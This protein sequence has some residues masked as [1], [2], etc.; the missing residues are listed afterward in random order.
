MPRKETSRPPAREA[1]GVFSES[2]RLR[3]LVFTCG[4]SLMAWEIAGSRVLG[5]YFGST[6]YVWGSLIGVIMG[7]LS[8]GYY[9]GGI[10]ADR[11]PSVGLLCSIVAAAGVVLLI[12]RFIAASVCRG[13]VT[14]PLGARMQPL[15]VSVVLFL[16][17]SVLLGMVSPF[18]VRR[19]AKSVGTMGNV[20]GRLYAL[21]TV[22]SIAGTLAAA[23]Y[24]LETFRVSTII[25]MLGGLL[26]ASALFLWLPG[27]LHKSRPVSA[28]LLAAAA[29]LC[30]SVCIPASTFDVL[31]YYSGQQ[32]IIIDELESAYQHIVVLDRT[33]GFRRQRVLKF[34]QYEQS[35][36]YPDSDYEPASRYTQLFYLPF[37]LKGDI[38]SVLIVGLGG[39]TGP[40]MFHKF[41]GIEIDAVEI[42]PKVVV[43]AEKHFGFKPDERM[44]VH[45][46]DGRVFIQQSEKKYDLIILD[47]YSIGSRI[48]FHLLTREFYEDVRSRLNPGG[49]VHSNIIAVIEGRRNRLYRSCLK[50]FNAVFGRENVYIFRK[51]GYGTVGDDESGNTAFIAVPDQK[52]RVGAAEIERRAH[53]LV[54]SGDFNLPSPGLAFHA[55]QYVHKALTENLDAVP[56]LTDDFAPVDLMIAAQLD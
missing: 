4:A 44:R 46:A 25:L 24:L 47:A 13:I 31:Q 32:P 14:M 43:A 51:R 33:D 35:S 20:A 5:P 22:G 30:I 16:P 8:L 10:L 56:L 11:R 6:I 52:R 3:L 15:L 1:A 50:T 21:S 2:M 17:A 26:I 54:K 27:I 40:R 45:V 29:A 12:D 19:E 48:P 28:L 41:D 34:D 7:A 39:G 55:K 42:D 53:R 38:R 18:A 23:F 49:V 9:V 37:I 36:V